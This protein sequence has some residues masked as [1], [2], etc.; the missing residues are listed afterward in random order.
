MRYITE[1]SIFNRIK[2]YQIGID[3]GSTETN[4]QIREIDWNDYI[5]PIIDIY[6][7]K[8]ESLFSQ[9]QHD[10]LRAIQQREANR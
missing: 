7:E 5:K 6:I 8:M 4:N 9:R 10:N 2:Q 3:Y 1:V